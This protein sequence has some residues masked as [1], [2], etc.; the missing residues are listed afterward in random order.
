M[1]FRRLNKLRAAAGGYFWQPCPL[2]G[3]FFG[4]HEWR[5]IDGK[6]SSIPTSKPGMG[7]GICPDCT[8]AGLGH[9]LIDL[10]PPQPAD[11]ARTSLLVNG[12]KVADG[13]YG[14]KTI[15]VIKGLSRGTSLADKMKTYKRA[16]GEPIHGEWKLVEDQEWLDDDA[17]EYSE[18]IEETWLC[19]DSRKFAL[20]ELQRWCHE[21]DEGIELDH[22]VNGRVY[23]D[24]HKPKGGPIKTQP[25]IV[26]EPDPVFDER[27]HP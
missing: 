19:I 20:G 27:G 21:C 26:G 25:Y 3:Q 2:C 24:A 10:T 17:G 7:Q 5:N 11:G 18:Y 8:R 4:G 9:E 13:D 23:C 16:D 22:P 6:S 1:R 12:Q 14:P 15:E